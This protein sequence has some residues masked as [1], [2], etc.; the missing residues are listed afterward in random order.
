MVNTAD[1]PTYSLDDDNDD[2]EP[3]VPI[4]QRKQAK[5]NSLL[6]RGAI[7]GDTRTSQTAQSQTEADDEDE[8]DAKKEQA[9]RERALLLEAQA[10][11]MKKAAEGDCPI[12]CATKGI[13]VERSRCSKNG[14]GEAGGG[15]RR[16]PEGNCEPQKPCI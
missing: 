4:A 5:L 11:H 7:G 3:Y 10:V 14:D 15:R 16:N 6:K 2:Y 9:R 1:T 13:M 8:E 12:S